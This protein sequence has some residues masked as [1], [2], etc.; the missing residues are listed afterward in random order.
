MKAGSRGAISGAEDGAEDE[1]EDEDD[2]DERE[3]IAARE[4]GRVW[5]R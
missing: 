5:R 4:R 3:G 2:A 1:Q